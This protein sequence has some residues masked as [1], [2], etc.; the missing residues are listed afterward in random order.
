MVA[1]VLTNFQSLRPCSLLHSASGTILPKP[2]VFIEPVNQPVISQAACLWSNSWLLYWFLCKTLALVR[3]VLRWVD[4]RSRLLWPSFKHCLPCWFFCCCCKHNVPYY[5]WLTFIFFLVI[6][7]NVTLVLYS[8][9]AIAKGGKMAKWV[10]LRVYLSFAVVRD[11]VYFLFGIVGMTACFPPLLIFKKFQNNQ[12][13]T[14]VKQ[15]PFVFDW[16]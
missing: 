13:L 11:I 9:K 1:N 2:I 3:Q 15:L 10:L 7:Y 4:M 5:E 8:L 6:Y 16:L 12:L 14:L